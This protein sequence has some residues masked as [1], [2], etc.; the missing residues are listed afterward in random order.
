M[1]TKHLYRVNFLVGGLVLSS[2]GC[3]AMGGINNSKVI[4]NKM[5]TKSVQKVR[6][7]MD[8][9]LLEITP[10]EGDDLSYEVEFFPDF[11]NTASP[12][13][14]ANSTITTNNNEAIKIHTGENLRTTA[15]VF[16][17]KNKNIIIRMGSGTMEIG[18]LTGNIDA[19]LEK[20][21]IKFDAS[22]LADDVCVWAGVKRGGVNNEKDKNC[23][24]QDPL[25]RLYTE[26]GSVTVK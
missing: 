8:R 2:F 24:I 6:I 7:E 14:Y 23:E 26:T 20:G 1:I 11:G 21:G 10:T 13:N 12:E 3:Y 17:P 5:D 4:S 22:G 19:R 18:P 15:R 9:G 16:V 25:V